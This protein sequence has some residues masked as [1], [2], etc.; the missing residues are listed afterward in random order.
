MKHWIGTAAVCLIV[1]LGVT[2]LSDAAGSTYLATFLE[3]NLLLA[4]IALLAINT[5]TSGVILS[6]LRELAETRPEIK[7]TKTLAAMREA[8]MEQVALVAVAVV[9]LVTKDSTWI[10]TTWPQSAFFANALLAAV[11]AYAMQ[12]MYDTAIAVYKIVDF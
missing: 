4:L 12:I 10:A 9:V 8:T 5:A 6:R 7:L 1:G 3:D 2:A 11:F